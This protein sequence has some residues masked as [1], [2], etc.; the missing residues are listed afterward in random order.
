MDFQ[1]NQMVSVVAPVRNLYNRLYLLCRYCLV[2]VWNPLAQSSKKYLSHQHSAQAP[3]LVEMCNLFRPA[4]AT[5]TT[6]KLGGYSICDAAPFTC[7]MPI[8]PIWGREIVENSLQS[9]L[10]SEKKAISAFV[11]PQQA[12][13]VVTSTFP[14]L[15]RTAAF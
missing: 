8:L 6:W 1:C 4:A 14:I 2:S 7:F 9:N 11:V 3:I 13:L 15:G 5:M 10:L 12:F